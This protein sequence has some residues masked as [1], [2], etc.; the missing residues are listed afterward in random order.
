MIPSAIQKAMARIDL[1]RSEAFAVMNAVIAGEATAAQISAFLVAMR[2]KG[3]RVQEIAGFA[4]AMRQHV[5]SVKTRHKHTLAMCSTGSNGG[6]GFNVSTVAALVV[7]GAGVPVAK[8]GCDSLSSRTGSAQ[9]LQ[10]L[11]INVH[12]TAEQMGACLDETG[13]A[14]LFA[15]ALHPAM[16]HAGNLC[17]EIGGCTFFNFLG[18]VTNPAGVRRHMIGVCDRRLTTVL[19]EVLAEFGTEQALLVHSDDGK[20]EVSLR[21]R[22]QTVEL[23]LGRISERALT[24]EDFGLQRSQ[25]GLTNGALRDHASL[26]LRLLQGG[27]EPMRN[28]VVANAACALTVA[29]AVKTLKEGVALAEETIEAGAAL[30]KLEALRRFTNDFGKVH[31][32]R[33]TARQPLEQPA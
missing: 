12:L 16:K 13:F 33:S 3:E 25:N 30:R 20:D 22:T 5:A 6:E 10:A 4:D 21:G 14:F 32:S 26:A 17:L 2:M 9:L 15:P 18:P 8:H 24:A 7:A 19:A 28:Q 27:R 31:N 1:S 11:G 23:M 29:N